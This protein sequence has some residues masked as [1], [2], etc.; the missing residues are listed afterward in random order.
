M[1]E[2]GSGGVTLKLAAKERL[3]ARIFWGL[4]SRDR[5]YFYSGS[6][7]VAVRRK[8]YL[9]IPATCSKKPQSQGRPSSLLMSRNVYPDRKAIVIP[10]EVYGI[11]VDFCLEAL[12]LE[13]VP[14]EEDL[15]L[16]AAY[17]L[18]LG[19]R[20]LETDDGAPDPIPIQEDF[21]S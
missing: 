7:A 6:C 11:L 15:G 8:T 10:N 18:G 21:A 9:S 19:M 20:A 4:P 3:V 5:R 1:W 17:L 12:G 16:V 2:T 13:D 14:S